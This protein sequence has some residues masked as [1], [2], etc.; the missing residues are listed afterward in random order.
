MTTT[1]QPKALLSVAEAAELYGVD[2]ETIRRWARTATIPGFKVSKGRNAP[3]RFRRAALEADMTR[4]EKAMAAGR[5][6]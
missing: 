1:P 2:P 5:V 4:R 6:A 3:Y